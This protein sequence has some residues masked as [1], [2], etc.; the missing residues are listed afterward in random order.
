MK[1]FFLV[2][3]CFI[4]AAAF[5]RKGALY[6]FDSKA[7]V[8]LR[9]LLAIGIILHHLSL[10]Y[11][12]NECINAFRISPVFYFREMG[13]PIVAIFFL[14]TGYGLSK[15]LQ[16][17]GTS[18]LSG[19]LKKRL[20]KILPEF[21]LFT[22]LALL[23]SDLTGAVSLSEAAHK[24]ATGY[25]PLLFSWFMYAI[26][27]VYLAFYL[28]ALISTSDCLRTGIVLS[29]FIA[30][31]CGIVIALKWGG[32]W[33]LSIPAVSIGYF[34]ALYENKITKI[35][36]VRYTPVC[37]GACAVI[38]A[39][40]LGHI[41]GSRIM[42]ALLFAVLTYVYMRLYSIRTY[43]ILV[44]LGE[45]SLY[46]YLVHGEILNATKNIETNKYLAVAI[47]I[48]AS[49]AVSVLIKRIRGFVE[50]REFR[51]YS[52]NRA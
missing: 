10:T 40:L 5:R 2:L 35:L 49:V 17:K 29:L 48:L 30:L 42:A 22:V 51:V 31:Y 21:L 18:Y 14:I 37:I 45:L 28:S 19:F 20:G 3:A 11:Q 9:G 47:V 24:M 38:Y 8:P 16:T 41:P 6:N 15:S 27:Y 50:N 12:F 52:K 44:L 4:A 1:L 36:S 23:F 7:T 26:V 34:T 43:S 25:P 13:G 32:W 33:Y 39:L 46:I